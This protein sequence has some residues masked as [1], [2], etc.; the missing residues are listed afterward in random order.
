MS[1]LSTAHDHNRTSIPTVRIPACIISNIRKHEKKL[2]LMY[3]PVLIFVKTFDLY[4]KLYLN[5]NIA[6]PTKYKLVIST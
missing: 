4:V 2:Q 3:L 6:Q 1:H 5:L